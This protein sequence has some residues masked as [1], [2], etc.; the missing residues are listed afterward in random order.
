MQTESRETFWVFSRRHFCK[1]SPAAA[2]TK[3]ELHNIPLTKEMHISVLMVQCQHLGTHH[4]FMPLYATLC[5]WDVLQW[6]LLKAQ[7]QQVTQIPN[8]EPCP[9][10]C[11]APSA[12]ALSSPLPQECDCSGHSRAGK[13]AALCLKCSL[14]AIRLPQ[15]PSPAFWE[16][17]METFLQSTT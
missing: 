1:V 8:N 13:P 10:F 7:K 4:N 12:N 15:A 11:S 17:S 14:R 6:A 3:L 9:S 16:C 5:H 2:E